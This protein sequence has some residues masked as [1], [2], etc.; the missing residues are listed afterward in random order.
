MFTNR[1]FYMFIVTA[2]LIGA[3][4]PQIPVTSR[5]TT[6]SQDKPITLRLA[7]ADEQNNPS[8]PYAL[9]FI[10]QVKTRSN[11]SITIQPIWNA[12]DSTDAGFEMG[13]IQ[14]VKKGDMELGLAAS[15]AFDKENI[16]SFEALQAPFLITNDNLAK[17]V[18]RSHI[19][20]QMLDDLKSSG[21]A[22]LAL[23][24]EDLRHP[25]SVVPGKPLL[26]PE[27]FT[28]LSIRTTPSNESNKLVEA[29]GGKPVFADSDYQGAESGLRQGYSLTG[30]PTATGN[31][32]FFAKYQVLFAN[33]AAFEKLSENQRS[34]LHGAA[35]ATQQK[36]FAE[37]P[38][39][40][41]AGIAWC[42]DGGTIVLASDE[43]VA[44]FEKAAQP[45]SDSI[46]QDA[47]NSQ[48]ITGIR[49]LKMK[50]PPS[51]E[52]Q[53]CTPAIQA[54][55]QPTAAPE[56]WSQG[57]PPNG[58]W[59]AEITADDF[60]RMGVLKSVA[61][62]DWAG[63]Y[64]ITFDNGKFIFDW[65][66]EQGQNGK[67]QAGYELI[68]NVVHLTYTS[69]YGCNNP[70]EDIQWRIDND[71]LHLHLVAQKGDFVGMKA[72][73]EAKPWQ[74][75]EQ[76][77]KDL[78]PNGVW[79]ARLNPEDLMAVGGILQSAANNQAGTHTFTFHD[80]KF[81][82]HLDADNP[83]NSGD[84]EGTYALVGDVNRLTLTGDCAP[85]VD[86]IQW[87]LDD[88]GLH[89]HLVNIK[90]APFAEIKANLEAK[91]Y[92]RIADQ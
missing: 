44:A 32:T 81:A 85:E 35:A 31:V 13:V 33:A 52:A 4:A 64:M 56:V 30:T 23:W 91:P 39:D 27:D 20:T 61:Q 60:V 47:F 90:N 89:L 16:T 54:N 53:A 87:R 76:W 34:I 74:K 38:S 18:A 17:A 65:R 3:C 75:V 66:G 79:Q 42:K 59:Q 26:S 49:E 63:S 40:A 45:V 67:C 86:D 5:T 43:Q 72:F 80:G 25:F 6:A 78:L 29:L 12:G 57:L 10:Q 9:E 11:G 2:L 77:S 51:S 70:E 22:G 14:L 41:D 82:W 68:D 48:M 36:A 50:T 46:T 71:G 21:L 83:D 19:S 88:Q 24:P 58:T 55:P 73:F 8:G 15:R 84:C 7:V 1:L 62:S 37:H 92:Q 28:G 69:L